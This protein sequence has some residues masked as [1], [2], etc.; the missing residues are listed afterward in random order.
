MNDRAENERRNRH[1]DHLDKGVAER[2]HALPDRRGEVPQDRAN[3][4]GN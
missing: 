4:D 3:E 1:L 2:L